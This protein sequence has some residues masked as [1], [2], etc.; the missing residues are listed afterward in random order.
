MLKKSIFFAVIIA[1]ENTKYKK[2]K[3]VGKIKRY[4]RSQGLGTGEG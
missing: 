1:I 3:Y 4:L 2:T